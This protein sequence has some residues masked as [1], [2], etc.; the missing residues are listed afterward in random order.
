MA[1][2]FIC[3]IKND[4]NKTAWTVKTELSDMDVLCWCVLFVVYV[5][6]CIETLCCVLLNCDFFIWHLRQFRITHKIRI[7]TKIEVYKRLFL[8]LFCFYC[9]LKPL[10][11]FRC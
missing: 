1:A 4:K 6:K 2:L 3:E 7:V 11:M 8:S 9:A 5:Y 10:S